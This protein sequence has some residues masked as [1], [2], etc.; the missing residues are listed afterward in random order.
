[1]TISELALQTSRVGGDVLSQ[2]TRVRSAEPRA[3]SLYVYSHHHTTLFTV[4]FQRCMQ[5]ERHLASRPQPASRATRSAQTRRP[6]PPPSHPPRPPPACAGHG[7]AHGGVQR[8]RHRPLARMPAEAALCARHRD[9]CTSRQSD[10]LRAQAAIGRPHAGHPFRCGA[11]AARRARAGMAPERYIG[12]YMRRAGFR[13][14]VQPP[15]EDAGMGART[16]TGAVP[17]TTPR[18]ALATAKASRDHTHTLSL[19]HTRT[20]TDSK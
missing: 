4:I 8:R 6:A 16:G 5:S 19:S 10:L 18:G 13:A 15:S 12:A 2:W 9:R 11:A 14:S 17:G 20:H 3:R 7:G 1:M